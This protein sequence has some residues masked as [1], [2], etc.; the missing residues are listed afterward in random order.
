[1]KVAGQGRGCEEWRPLSTYLQA[2]VAEAV[3]AVVSVRVAPG[4]GTDLAVPQLVKAAPLAAL[5]EPLLCCMH[6]PG[7]ACMHV[8]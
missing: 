1:M 2:Y 6:P 4:S 5:H 3:G 7:P 8:G